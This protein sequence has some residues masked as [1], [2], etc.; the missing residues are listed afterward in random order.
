[1]KFFLA[2]AALVVLAIT[3]ASARHPRIWVEQSAGQEVFDLEGHHIGWIERYIDISGTPGAIV[4]ASNSVSG[5]Q[6]LVA[7][8]NLTKRFD[9]GYLLM[10]SDSSVANLPRYHPGWALPIW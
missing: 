8:A 4:R 2:C 1:M 3:P 6:F 7:A 9:G 10:L 5:N